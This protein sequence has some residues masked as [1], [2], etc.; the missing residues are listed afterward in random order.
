MHV[1]R[2]QKDFAVPGAAHF[3]PLMRFIIASIGP[4]YS[5]PSA[6]NNKSHNTNISMFS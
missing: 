3:L 4:A 6:C 2:K 1:I 5:S